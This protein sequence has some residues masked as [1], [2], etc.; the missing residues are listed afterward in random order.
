MA[1]SPGSRALLE[2]AGAWS[3]LQDEAQPIVEMAIYDGTRRDAVRLEQLRFA[4]PDRSPL[5]H[6]AFNDDVTFALR[7]AAEKAGVAMIEGAVAEFNPQ[8]FATALK[9]A[10]QRPHASK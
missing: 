2:R 7:G 4:Q 9:L 3:V 6:M 1:L 10:T 5:A 8:P